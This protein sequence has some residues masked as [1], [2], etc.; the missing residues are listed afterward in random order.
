MVGCPYSVLV[1]GPLLVSQVVR[2][3]HVA[4]APIGPEQGMVE[5]GPEVLVLEV[6]QGVASLSGT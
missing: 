3:E 6:L 2:L 4:T 5:L 1:K